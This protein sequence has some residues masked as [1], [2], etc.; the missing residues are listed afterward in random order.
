M[1]VPSKKLVKLIDMWPTQKQ[2]CEK[3]GVSEATMTRVLKGDLEVPKPL[4]ESLLLYTG[5][6]FEDLFDIDEPTRRKEDK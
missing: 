6:G 4:M 2:F 1:I 5:W 3:A